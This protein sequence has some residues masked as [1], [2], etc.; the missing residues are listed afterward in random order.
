MNEKEVLLSKFIA[1]LKELVEMERRAEI[2]AMRLEMRRL[3]GREREKVGRAVLGLNG[4]V[5]G[6]ELG[7]FLVRY[8]RDRE[9]KTE[10]S[11]GDLVVI[12]K[13]DPLK[14]DL[15]GTVV[16]KGKRF[17]TVAI[18]TVPEWALK[19]V[20][21]DLYANDITFKRW[22]ENLDNLRESGRKAL[23][24]YLGLREPEE[25][26]PVEFQ[27]FD[28]SLNA[29]QRG[30][31]AKA[32]GSGDFFLV[33]GPFGTGKTRT[34]VELIRQEVAR[35]HKVLATA[36]SNVA[37]DNI[38][39]RLADSG[40]KVVRIGHPSRVSKALHETTLAYLITQHDLYAE[41]RELRVIGENLKEKRDTFTKPAPKYRR[42]L[43]DRE[44]LRLAEKGIGTRGVP[45]RLIREMAEWIRI[46]QQVQK[47]FDDAR[48]L[49]ERIA[50]EIIQEADVVLTTN[51]SAGL[52]VV[53]Y[54]EYDVAV[55]DEATQATIPS[56]LIPINRAKRF[57][58]AGDHK[59][60]PPT[61]LSE[62]AKELSKT[63]FEGLI[64][65]YPEKSEMLTVQYRMNERLMEF[66]SREFYDGK[67]KAHESVKNITLADLGVSEPEFG[68]FWDE[69]L[70]PE[71][72]LVFIDTSK[73]EDRFER[74]RRGSDSRENPLEAKLVT[75]TVEKLL[76]MGVKPDWIGVITPYDDQ[77]DLISSMVGEDI[78]VK[79]VDGYQ[80]REK[81][82]IVLSF[83]RSNRRGELGF[84]TDLRR[85]NVSLT[86]A[87]RKL[88][89]VGDSSTLSNH[90][91]YR[92]F[93]EFVRERGTF[94]EIDG[95]KH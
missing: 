47:T 44:I 49:E 8:G 89:A 79:T 14:S 85:L 41:L 59:Q 87:K 66:P 40:L 88:I 23:E 46:N 60:L 6:E 20:R 52:E 73:R 18:E 21:I 7:Y 22:M 69:A 32:L 51:A 5:I 57:V 4:K 93:I 67:I 55:I 30:A 48:K 37:V 39:E 33:H 58:L 81:E 62:K 64:E 42:G 27:P 1:H 90:P 50:R 54:G 13:R 95:K 29:S 26:E 78:E 72:V 43:S 25:S 77:R 91:T 70:K 86:R 36:E 53:D 11:V 19:G 12:S 80:G 2:E 82:I 31:I 56:V 63:L 34:L 28:K 68:N 94:I 75:E 83:V 9:I 74:Q 3:S 71:N 15:V 38:V 65:R 61:I 17:L 16:E 92:R 35:G 76:E 84:L 10:I 45:A 24:L